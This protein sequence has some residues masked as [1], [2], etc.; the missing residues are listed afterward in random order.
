V[1]GSG[2]KG[3]CTINLNDVVDEHFFNFDLHSW[4]AVPV[5]NLTLLW[6]SNKPFEKK[7]NPFSSS[8]NLEN[9]QK[10]RGF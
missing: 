5:I 2:P 4:W 6:R 10:K 9:T 8:K 7:F 1:V 3:G